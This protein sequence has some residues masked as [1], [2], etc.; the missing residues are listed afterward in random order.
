MNV[1]IMRI[2]RFMLC[3]TMGS[4]L[5][6]IKSITFLNPFIVE[7]I[8]GVFIISTNPEPPFDD[9]LGDLRVVM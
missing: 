4:L 2:P 5:F 1:L 9:K 3:P 7:S 6:A 8:G